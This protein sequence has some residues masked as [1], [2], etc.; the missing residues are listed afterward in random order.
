MDADHD[1]RGAAASKP[2]QRLCVC[3]V[4][5]WCNVSRSR[6]CL[7][8]WGWAQAGAR[9]VEHR[10]QA[11][12]QTKGKAAPNH[13]KSHRS[14]AGHSFVVFLVCC[15]QKSCS[16]STMG[17]GKA[18]EKGT[19]TCP[20]CSSFSRPCPYTDCP[21][22]LHPSPVHGNRLLCRQFFFVLNRRNETVVQLPRLLFCPVGG[23]TGRSPS[24]DALDFPPCLSS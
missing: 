12:D 4:C 20:P 23:S 9:R 11:S 1:D 15:L 2:V 8:V 18:Q 13:A 24:R 6:P 10:R 16:K 21:Q 19:H 7:V 22:M 17:G 5:V 14:T 3:V